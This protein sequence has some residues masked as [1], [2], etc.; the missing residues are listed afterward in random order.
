LL[1]ESSS[2][3]HN[4]I[5]SYWAGI[6]EKAV[7]WRSKIH[8]STFHSKPVSTLLDLLLLRKRRENVWLHEWEA[9]RAW[10]HK[11]LRIRCHRKY[12]S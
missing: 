3:S 4:G 1:L 6:K 10:H 11:I 2:R 8:C 12:R 5:I 7:R 9:S